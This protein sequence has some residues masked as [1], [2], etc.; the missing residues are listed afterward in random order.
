M[1]DYLLRPYR[2]GTNKIV[3]RASA[4]VHPT[5]NHVVYTNSDLTADYDHGSLSREARKAVRRNARRLADGFRMRN[6]SD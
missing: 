3:A 6:G 5:D 1:A 2:S 4:E